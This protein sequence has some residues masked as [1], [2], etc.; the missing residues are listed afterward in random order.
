[1]TCDDIY[2]RVF[3]IA[4]LN[5]FYNVNAIENCN[6]HNGAIEINRDYRMF[7]KMILDRSFVSMHLPALAT[8]L[9]QMLKNEI[10]QWMQV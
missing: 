4:S 5:V 8:D 9:F 2:T 10:D 1:M 7:E 6:Y 3:C